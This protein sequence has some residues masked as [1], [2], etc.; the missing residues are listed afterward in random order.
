VQGYGDASDAQRERQRALERE[1]RGALP[2]GQISRVYQ[3]LHELTSGRVKKLEAL[4]RWHHPAWGHVSPTEFI[5]IAEQSGLIVSLGEWILDEACRQAKA[6]ERLTGEG[7]EVSVNVSPVQFAQPGFYGAVVDALEKNGLMPEFLGLELTEGIVMHGV[8]H[9]T[10]T[11]ARLQRLGVS[12]AIDDFGT[13]Y[14]SLAYLRDLPI[15]TIKIDR[16][17]VNDLDSPVRGPQFALALIEA[18]TRVAAHLDLEIVAKG[19]ETEGQRRLLQELGCHLG[20]GYLFSKP[21]PAADIL[22]YLDRP[23]AEAPYGADALVN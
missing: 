22:P 16:S 7:V 20:Q 1:L 4:V 8:D 13:G 14:S 11:L 10:S 15:D 19:V 23:G 6:W 3:P 18:I 2:D 5:P 21:L 9:V 17:F 12:I